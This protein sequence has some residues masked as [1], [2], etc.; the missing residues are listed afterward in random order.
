MRTIPIIIVQNGVS[1]FIPTIGAGGRQITMFGV[2]TLVVA[3]GAMASGFGSDLD[4]K[5]GGKGR[6]ERRPFF[7]RP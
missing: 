7:I 4:G 6:P 2:N 1:R 3:I 5:V